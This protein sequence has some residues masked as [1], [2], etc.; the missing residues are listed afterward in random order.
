[1]REILQR[2]P[3][4]LYYSLYAVR[5]ASPLL[6]IFVCDEEEEGQVQALGQ[7]FEAILGLSSGLR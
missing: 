3:P 4:L 7:L 1:M 2:I 5:I 6:G